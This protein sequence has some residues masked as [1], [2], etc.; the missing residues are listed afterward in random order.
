LMSSFDKPFVGLLAGRNPVKFEVDH[1][2]LRLA[3][4]QMTGVRIAPSVSA[5][6]GYEQ[7]IFRRLRA[8][9]TLD[10][11]KD[12]PIFR[13]FRDL[14]WSHGMDPTKLRVSSEALLRRVLVGQNLWRV[15]DVVDVANLASVAH[16]LPVGL[17]DL[18]KLVGDITVRNAH[19]GEEFYRIGGG[20]VVCRGREIVLADAE[21]IICFGYATHDSDL[22]RVTDETNDVLLLVFGSP[23]VSLEYMLRSAHDTLKIAE[24]WLNCSV[25]GLKV[26]S[27]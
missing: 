13:S 20:T 22:T 16:H 7:D 24:R 12:D 2:G 4:I 15:N 3:A 26:F 18:S 21:K 11:L 8:D 19:M 9:T 10:S 5:F 27:S 1:H 17:V 23:A 14:Y 25:G 6:E